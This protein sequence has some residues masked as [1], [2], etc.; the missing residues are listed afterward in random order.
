LG[1]RHPWIHSPTEVQYIV[2]VLP[3]WFFCSLL[4]SSKFFL[5]IFIL[6]DWAELPQ[7][8]GLYPWNG[9]W[10]CLVLPFVRQLSCRVFVGKLFKCSA[11]ERHLDVVPQGVISPAVVFLY[12]LV[13]VH[14]LHDVLVL[15]PCEHRGEDWNLICAA[16]TATGCGRG[17][18]RCPVSELTRLLAARRSPLRIDVRLRKSE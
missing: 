8:L 13:T 15:P 17:C 16:I 18:R 4:P 6:I 11:G 14:P 5:I 7:D 1:L 10:S 9:R 3:C 2:V 12:S